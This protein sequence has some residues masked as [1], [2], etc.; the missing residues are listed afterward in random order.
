MS[1]NSKESNSQKIFA[2]SLC[3]SC[4]E[5]F[6]CGAKVGECWC[7][8]VESDGEVLAMLRDEFKDCLCQDCLQKSS[9]E[10]LDASHPA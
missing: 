6:G 3:A 5:E 2:K 9:R 4:G 1:A 10:F 7:F 8:E